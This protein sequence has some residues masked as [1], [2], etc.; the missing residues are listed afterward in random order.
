MFEVLHSGLRAAPEERLIPQER[1]PTQ[2][3]F[4]FS[5]VRARFTDA[6]A[7]ALKPGLNVLLR[8]TDDDRR[9]LRSVFE[10]LT[11]AASS[12]LDALV[13][14]DGSMVALDASFPYLH[15][16]DGLGPPVVDVP[17]GDDPRTGR[18]TRDRAHSDPSDQRM[19]E[20]GADERRLSSELELTRREL[21]REWEREAIVDP[22]PPAGRGESDLHPADVAVMCDRLRELLAMDRP[23]EVLRMAGRLEDVGR[24]RVY[25]IH[26]EEALGQLIEECRAAERSA[27]DY[28]DSV[29]ASPQG[30][31]SPGERDGGGRV[32][33][34]SMEERLEAGTREAHTIARLDLLEE[35][36]DFWK[37]RLEKLK[38]EV[39][40][41]NDLLADANALLASAGELPS[42]SLRDAAARLREHARRWDYD[43][44]TV[45]ELV[46]ALAAYL[47]SDPAAMAPVELLA[48]AERRLAHGGATERQGGSAGGWRAR[49]DQ[50]LVELEAT[51]H[52]LASQLDT[53]RAEL[54]ALERGREAARMQSRPSGGARQPNPFSS[55]DTGSPGAP[56][57]GWS[58]ADAVTRARTVPGVGTLPVLLLEASHDAHAVSSIDPLVAAS[59]GNAGQVVWVTDRPEVLS[60]LE[61]LGEDV[62]IIGA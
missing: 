41:G 59:M 60:A 13:D 49:D 4:R 55:P 50:R 16:L 29:V 52:R 8:P 23:T 62:G 32:E 1:D 46:E 5:S 17:A 25:R 11:G 53:A 19:A 36:S 43:E 44:A 40:T 20:L 37:G 22:G 35:L 27:Q 28:L 48:E 7:V 39:T 3:V 58:L 45:D 21:Q 42:G 6:P 2:R 33:N 24:R 61:S 54:G 14:L 15:G 10:S 9:L 31:D 26:R 38:A 18:T 51:E 47:G 30:P 34:M 12:G 56:E 57:A